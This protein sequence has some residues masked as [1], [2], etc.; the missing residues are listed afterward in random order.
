MHCMT[1]IEPLEEAPLEEAPPYNADIAVGE[2]RH[3][4]KMNFLLGCGLEMS[5]SLF[6]LVVVASGLTPSLLQLEAPADTEARYTRC[7]SLASFWPVTAL[8]PAPMQWAKALAIASPKSCDS[9]GPSWNR[10]LP[11]RPT[12]QA[13]SLLV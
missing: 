4:C 2:L 13:L 5:G 11:I 8:P 1:L 6:K 3:F 12:A 10:S 9:R 7:T